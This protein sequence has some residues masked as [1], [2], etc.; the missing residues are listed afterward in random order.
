MHEMMR[1]KNQQNAVN[2]TDLFY[3]NNIQQDA[4]DTGTYLPQT[5]ST[6]FGCLSHPSSG[7]HKL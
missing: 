6:R 5:Y 2:S 1:I 7:V 3:I 4:T